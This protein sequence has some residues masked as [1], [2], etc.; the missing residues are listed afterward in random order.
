MKPEQI[1]SY[2]NSSKCPLERSNSVWTDV[3]YFL[4]RRAGEPTRIKFA[5]REERE[6]YNR[7]ILQR[8]GVN[9]DPFV[10]LNLHRIGIEVP[11]KYVYEE[12]LRWNGDSTCWPNN[13]A[14]VERKDNQLDH[15]QLFLFGK[16]NYP[17]GFKKSFLGIKY[18]PLFNMNA[19]RIEDP[20]HYELDN[21]RYLLYR[22]SGGYP[23]GI[24]SMFVRTSIKEYQ[25]T[26]AS[27][28]FLLVGFNFFGKNRLSRI[29][30]VQKSWEMFHNRVTSNI[31]NRFKILCE[32]RFRQ[33]LEREKES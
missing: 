21:A 30:I 15:I 25:E 26:E 20:D 23:I 31:M 8:I 5:T 33:F 29:W 9:P 4:L 3:K 18:I 12:L 16:K 19:F 17:F 6:D 2:S 13:I 24:F 11:T 32:W 22:C 7:R 14:R 27:Q 28:L 1:N 10:I